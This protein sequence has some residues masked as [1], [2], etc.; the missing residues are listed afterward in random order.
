MS[1]TDLILGKKRSHKKKKKKKPYIKENTVWESIIESS[2]TSKIKS[3]KTKVR[4]AGITGED[5]GVQF[6]TLSLDL[7]SGYMIIF[8]LQKFIRLNMQICVHFFHNS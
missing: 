4:I 6:N 2:N 5:L 3:A 8:N 1:L 7:G